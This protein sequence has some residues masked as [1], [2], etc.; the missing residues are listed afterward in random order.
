MHFG[1]SFVFALIQLAVSE[2]SA[3]FFIQSFTIAQMHGWWS[4]SSPHPKQN[5][6][7]HAHRTEGTIESSDLG[8][9]PGQRIA[10]SQFG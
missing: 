8:V 9:I 2:S 3:H 10:N 4:V 7:P 6:F 5:W 1:H